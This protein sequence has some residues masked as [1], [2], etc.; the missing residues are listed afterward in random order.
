A[1][2][3]TSMGMLYRKLL[4]RL[5]YEREV[6]AVLAANPTGRSAVV[7]PEAEALLEDATVFGTP[8]QA[9]ARLQRWYETGA[10]VPILL[11]KP[12]LSP[13]EITFTLRAIGSGAS[14]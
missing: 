2:Y 7:P 5:G 9:R 10:A 1:F 13:S 12:G 8:A 14:A 6:E 3:L 11:L 4:G